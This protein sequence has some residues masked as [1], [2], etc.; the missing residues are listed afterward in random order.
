[1]SYGHQ[2]QVWKLSGLDASQKY[3]LLAVSFRANDKGECWPSASDLQQLTGLNIKTVRRCLGDLEKLGYVMRIKRAGTSDLLIV[4]LQNDCPKTGL[5]KLGHTQNREYPKTVEGVT[6]NRAGGLPKLG[7][8]TSKEQ[9]IEQV[10]IKEI[11]KEKTATQRRG[12]SFSL[13]SIPEDWIGVANEINPDIDPIKFFDDFADYWRGVPGE[14]GRKKDWLATWR[15]ALRN[16]PEWKKKNF[17][18]ARTVVNNEDL[19]AQEGYY[20]EGGLL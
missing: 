12:T 9:V 1:M 17:L 5:P 3:V 11:D 8:R 20:E 19:W 10:N 14:K 15:N 16:I 13:E 4:H 6:Q 18:K 2:D 7:Y